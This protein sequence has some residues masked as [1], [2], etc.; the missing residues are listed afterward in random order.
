MPLVT[1]T[2]TNDAIGHLAD[3]IGRA[4]TLE[5]LVR[6]LLEILEALTGMESTYFTS[7]DEVAGLQTVLFSRN[8]LDL[9]IPERLSVPWG[10]TLCQ[11]AL[12]EGLTDTDDVPTLWGDSATARELGI[13]SYVSTPVRLQDGYLYGTLCAASAS[14]VSLDENARHVLRLF[15]GLISQQLERERLVQA[16]QAANTALSTS[17][18][19]DPVTGLPN[20]RALAKELERRIAHARRSGEAVLVAYLDLDGFKA[21]NDRHGH[22]S[23]DQFLAAIGC[24]LSIGLRADDFVARL[25]GDEFVA[26]ASVPNHDLQHATSAF[27]ARLTSCTCGEFALDRVSIDYGGPSI[28]VV[29]AHDTDDDIDTLIARADAA[30]YEVKRL[31]RAV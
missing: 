18:L 15:S 12:K 13:R 6:P 30:M 7:I 1:A 10:D 19:T 21:I 16:L 23:G 27:L 17:L 26:V 3:A 2:E 8:T 5:E 25:G 22:D 4:R 20:R 28:G 11:R 14:A 31:R 29:A 24:A 9:Q